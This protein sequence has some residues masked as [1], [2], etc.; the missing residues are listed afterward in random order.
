MIRWVII[1][2]A[3]SSGAFCQQRIEGKVVDRET[4]KPV[5][6]ASVGI[7]SLPRGTSSN[8]DGEFSLVVPDTFSIKVTCLGYKSVVVRSTENFS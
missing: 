7:E 4:G 8:I 6:F 5:P 3:I 2:L 1:F